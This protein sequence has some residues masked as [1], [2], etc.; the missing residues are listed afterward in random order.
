MLA[1]ARMARF[2]AGGLTLVLALSS[3]CTGSRM[4]YRSRTTAT[5]ATVGGAGL[6]IAGGVLLAPYAGPGED[7][8]GNG[9]DD[10][11]EKDL[12]CA[13]GGC[14]PGMGLLALGAAL[15]TSGAAYLATAPREVPPAPPP[16]PQETAAP[17]PG[18]VDVRLVAALP[19]RA[20]DGMT[21]QLARQTRALVRRGHCDAARLTVS[22]IRARDPAY[23]EA[24]VASAAFAGCRVT[25]P[26]A[27]R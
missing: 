27:I 3:G 6:M 12:A 25:W 14:F 8:D 2:V 7:T 15:A 21:L 13:F 17:L 24:L 20:C 1:S 4:Q 19:D 11:P 18:A 16:L 26:S 5:M 23:A 10:F 22:H 9:R